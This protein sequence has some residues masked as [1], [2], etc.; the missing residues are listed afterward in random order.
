MVPAIAEAPTGWYRD[1][2]GRVFQITFDLQKR[3]YMGVGW[4]PGFDLSQGAAVLDRVR[5][6]MGLVAWWLSPEQRNRHTIRALE[7]YVVLDDLEVEGLLFAYD[8]SHASTTPLLR[9]TTF[10]GKPTRHDLFMD[11]GFGLSLGDLHVHPHRVDE[12]VELEFGEVHVAWDAWQS[13]DLYNHL[14]LMAGLGIGGLWDD[15]RG[16]EAIFAL[17]PE[18]ALESRFGLD[19]DG[20]HYLLGDFHATMPVLL[21]GDDVGSTKSRVG[22]NAAYEVIFLAINDQPLSLRLEAGLDYRDDLPAD[23]PKW[24]A[25]LMAGVRF[26]FWAPARLHEDLPFAGRLAGRRR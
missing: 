6:D 7:G 22:A 24:D 21:S 14:R 12:L 1:E 13:A 19:R 20:F 5:F 17:L 26:S 2:K 8:L 15:R 3:F 4:L 25:T 9:I 10:F 23:A 11:I 18:L 16:S